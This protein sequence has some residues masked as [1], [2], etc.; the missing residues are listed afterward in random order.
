MAGQDKGKKPASATEGYPTLQ[1]GS[2]Q[3]PILPED[4]PQQFK[5]L[6]GCPILKEQQVLLTALRR[7]STPTAKLNALNALNYYF[8]KM[9]PN[10][11]E[12]PQKKAYVLFQGEKPGLYRSYGSLM[13]AIGKSP[14][15]V[16]KGF[17]SLE[18]A[19]KEAEDYFLKSST[20]TLSKQEADFFIETLKRGPEQEFEQI[21]NLV[22]RKNLD[23]ERRMCS[24]M[25]AGREREVRQFSQ[26]IRELEE[27]LNRAEYM[28]D[29]MQEVE[30]IP[31][32]K[33]SWM[34]NL[35]SRFRRSFLQDL[36]LEVQQDI[37]QKAE[38][39]LDADLI[40]MQ[41]FLQ[42][43]RKEARL[44]YPHFTFVQYSE[45]FD[46]EYPLQPSPV[47]LRVT[48]ADRID[49]AIISECFHYGFIHYLTFRSAPDFLGPKAQK[50]INSYCNQTDLRPRPPYRLGVYSS[51]PKMIQGKFIPAQHH[52]V[53]GMFTEFSSMFF[54]DSILYY[55]PDN[56]DVREERVY[57]NFPHDLGNK[58]QLLGETS[59]MKI[60]AP[61]KRP[62][63]DLNSVW[64][65]LSTSEAPN[66]N[67]EEDLMAEL[68]DLM[69]S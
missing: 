26:K 54:T 38:S 39:S 19:I 31:F 62:H 32:E 17:F 24:R 65:L 52:L 55:Q 50:I 40:G 58:F 63:P 35:D 20:E 14:K 45:Y 57:N 21:S 9:S 42:Q 43:S 60:W 18:D 22:L 12:K 11:L 10:D 67:E 53:I 44:P 29:A 48:S 47:L 8:S 37:L 1:F 5:P 61:L 27:E 30:T 3:L 46:N 36:P 2:Q 56:Q 68:E 13:K 25:R 41:M 51:S 69:E 59:T 49:E 23:H 34:M 16:F 28:I 6:H 64:D 7:A 66:L 4:H 15:P 33:W